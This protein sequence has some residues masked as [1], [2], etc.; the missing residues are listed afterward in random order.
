MRKRIERRSQLREQGWI[1]ERDRAAAD[2]RLKADRRQTVRRH[3]A[4]VRTL[5]IEMLVPN[6][7]LEQL[8]GMHA[9]SSQNV[10]QQ[11]DRAECSFST[12]KSDRVRDIGPDRP[13]LAGEMT[14]AEKIRDIRNYPAVAMLDKQIVIERLDVLMHGRE[15]F[16][17]GLEV[18]PK[19]V[20][21][22]RFAR[23]TVE[24]R[25]ILVL[26]LVDLRQPR[27]KIDAFRFE[28]IGRR[29]I[30]FPPPR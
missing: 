17:Y 29:H 25:Q 20:R 5:V 4:L 3:S 23:L 11:F 2:R 9:P 1:A 8:D 14:C 27:I 28:I 10:S 22:N 24:V 6:K 7:T 19:L 15:H 30:R 16:G 21:R 26:D 18:Q 12:P 13:F